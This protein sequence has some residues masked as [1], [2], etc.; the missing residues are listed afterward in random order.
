MASVEL[1][2]LRTR[3]VETLHDW[4]QKMEERGRLL[5]TYAQVK[6]L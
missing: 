4:Q 1:G 5:P 6:E 3:V 2:L